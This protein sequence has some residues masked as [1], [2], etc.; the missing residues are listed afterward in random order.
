MNSDHLLDI[1]SNTRST[2]GVSKVLNQTTCALYSLTNIDLSFL[3]SRKKCDDGCNGISRDAF[4][5]LCAFVWRINTKSS[6][7]FRFALG[8]PLPTHRSNSIIT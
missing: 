3:C 2:Y 6:S 8:A 1:L 7:A 4:C 5:K